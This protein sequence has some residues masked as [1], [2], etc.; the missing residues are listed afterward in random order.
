MKINL[1]Y[2][3]QMSYSAYERHALEYERQ[4]IKINLEYK[5]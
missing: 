1:E 5:N 2:K 4:P 3:N